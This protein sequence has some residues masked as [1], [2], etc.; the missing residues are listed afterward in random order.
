MIFV[1]FSFKKM[2]NFQKCMFSTLGF[3][4]Q[5]SSPADSSDSDSFEDLGAELGI[6]ELVPEVENGGAAS[7]NSVLATRDSPPTDKTPEK[8]PENSHPS[9]GASLPQSLRT[10][11][12]GEETLLPQE[13]QSSEIF[14][15]L[16]DQILQFFR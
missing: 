10:S 9:T 3:L 11:S 7:P 4:S 13:P 16:C 1:V 14:A 8:T 5:S 6:L 2:S 12:T 15:E